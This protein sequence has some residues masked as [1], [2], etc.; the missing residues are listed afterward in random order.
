M[1]G[2]GTTDRRSAARWRRIICIAAGVSLLV[3]VGVG[4]AWAQQ[5]PVGPIP[6][7][8]IGVGP[9]E[10]PQDVSVTLQILLLLTILT[11]APA[12]LVMTTA[13]TRIVIVLSFLRTALGAQQIPP[14]QVLIGLSLFL[15]FFVMAPVLNDINT[16]ALSPYLKGDMEFRDAIKEGEKPLREFMIRQ[17]RPKDVA[18]FVRLS[19]M[20]QPKSWDEIPTTTLIP[21]F[22]TSELKTGFLMGFKIY[23][24]FLVLDMVV[25]SVLMSM[26]MLMLPPMMISLPAKVLLFVLVD[27]WHQI[28]RALAASFR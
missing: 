12:I 26:G 7:I 4:I 25:A 1:H 15:T 13:F 19:G 16:K 5:K 8:T 17:A 10:S 22:V 24:P 28:V 14:N 3:A 9:S 21:A 20:N 23:I 11:L 2:V 18:L 6:R 27:G